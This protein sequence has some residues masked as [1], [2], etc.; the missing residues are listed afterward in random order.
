MSDIDNILKSYNTKIEINNTKMAIN[1]KKIEII[2]LN[3]QYKG[4][5]RKE[6]ELLYQL[7]SHNECIEYLEDKI[8]KIDMIKKNKYN[9]DKLT[10]EEFK[11]IQK[12]EK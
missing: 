4:C 8:Y 3:S 12:V 10:Y 5:L 1:N 7:D 6:K 11:L 9:K 2:W